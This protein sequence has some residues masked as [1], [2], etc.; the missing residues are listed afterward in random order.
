[1]FDEN[2]TIT[3]FSYEQEPVFHFNDAGS[4]S[5]KLLIITAE[6]CRDSIIKWNYITTSPQPTIDFLADPEISMMS[7]NNGAVNF[8]AYLSDNVVDNPSNHI[9]WTFGDGDQVE[10]ETS[11]SHTYTS[12]G[13]YTVTLALTTDSGCGDSVSHTVVIEDDL[14]FPNVITPNGDGINDVWAIEN[15]NT[16]INPEDP[17]EYRHNELR[18]SDRY[19]KVVFHVKNYDTWAKDGQIYTGLNPFN[20]DGLSDGVYFFTFTYKGKAK[21]FSWHGSI[22]IVR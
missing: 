17:D 16:D 9:V 1:M 20:G 5:I 13:D 2:F 19:G 6:G 22:T 7:E 10:N 18:I 11:T 14:R 4:Y 15:L 8:T 12:W 3:D 21:T